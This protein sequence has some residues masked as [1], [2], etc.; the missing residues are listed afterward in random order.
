M[1]DDSSHQV[2][3]YPNHSK[4]QHVSD[5]SSSACDVNDKIYGGGIRYAM[6]V[7]RMNAPSANGHDDV[8]HA[9]FLCNI[10]SS[11]SEG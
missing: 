11:S 4:L 10:P 9:R 2:F 8:H 3:V 6:R 7:G 1:L 5:T